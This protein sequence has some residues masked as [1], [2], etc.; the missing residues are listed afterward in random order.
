MDVYR[1]FGG[2]V[3]GIHFPSLLPGD[4]VAVALLPVKEGLPPRWSVYSLQSLIC[5]CLLKSE[6]QFH[7]VTNQPVPWKGM[8]KVYSSMGCVVPS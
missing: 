4:K 8:G 2:G 6:I 1:R 3:G 7:E 5:R